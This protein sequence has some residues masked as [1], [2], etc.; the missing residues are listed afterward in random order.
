MSAIANE[1]GEVR[2]TAGKLFELKLADAVG[3][4]AERKVLAQITDPAP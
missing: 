3:S 1:V 2:M 4:W